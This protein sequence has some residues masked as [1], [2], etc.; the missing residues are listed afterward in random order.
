VV[1][2]YYDYQCNFG[3]DMCSDLRSIYN[4]SAGEYRYFCAERLDYDNTY[5]YNWNT[6]DD[7]YSDVPSYQDET[8]NDDYDYDDN[9]DYF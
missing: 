4:S 5:D 7:F 6:E 1:Q 3:Y 8:D 2:T 9:W